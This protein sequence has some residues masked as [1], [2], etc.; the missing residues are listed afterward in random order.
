MILCMDIILR[1][2]AT[3]PGYV[4]VFLLIIFLTGDGLTQQEFSDPFFQSYQAL[5]A[6]EEGA[7]VATIDSTVNRLVS[8]NNKQSGK[9]DSVVTSMLIWHAKWKSR[10]M[11]VDERLAILNSHRAIIQKLR[12]QYHGEIARFYGLYISVFWFRYQA[13]SVAHYLDLIERHINEMKTPVDVKIQW[14]YEKGRYAS[15]QGD[16][17]A[18]LT[19]YQRGLEYVN[20]HFPDQLRIKYLLQN[21]IGIGYRRIGNATKAIRHYEV[22]LARFGYEV[23]A[24]KMTGAFLNNLGLA[25]KDQ[26][27]C[28][29]SI[30]RISDAIDYYAEN[31]SPDYADIGSG[32]DNIAICY[33]IQGKLDSALFFSHK[34]LE[35][36]R[37]NL[38]EGHPDLLLP[39][40]GITSV[41]LQKKKFAEALDINTK[42]KSLLKDLGWSEDAPGGDY[43][44]ADGFEVFSY[45]VAIQRSYL[46][47]QPTHHICI[48][49]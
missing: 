46:T 49:R 41:L 48:V 6:S 43:Y 5:V 47:K 28:V 39:M 42:A 4:L 38:G 19:F 2:S 1:S 10:N 14:L 33:Q 7:D 3:Y 21:A 18:A 27:D 29:N 32:Y 16:Y 8:I 25:Y 24:V 12:T 22:I 31:F 36:I 17:E 13:D 30:R 9:Y 20:K 35:F 45:A 37:Q 34:S 11:S 23:H 26:N 15:H 44:L 40:N